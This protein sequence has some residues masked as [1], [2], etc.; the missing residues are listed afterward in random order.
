MKMA[1][2]ISK[3]RVFQHWGARRKKKSMFFVFCFFQNGLHLLWTF[4]HQRLQGLKFHDIDV[5][6]DGSDTQINPNAFETHSSRL[7][8]KPVDD[9]EVDVND[10]IQPNKSTDSE[11][12]NKPSDASSDEKQKSLDKR[13]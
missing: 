12:Q 10:A 13:R 8:Q 7:T 3:N 11:K 1:V 5:T 4:T 2:Q 6:T 9:K